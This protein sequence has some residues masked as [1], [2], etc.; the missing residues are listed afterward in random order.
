MS[1]GVGKD[2]EYG[3]MGW[4]AITSEALLAMLRQVE[5][6]ESADMVYAEH[7]ANSA[8]SGTGD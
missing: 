3:G 8:I 4:W 7:Y 6:G 1:S 5:A 2:D